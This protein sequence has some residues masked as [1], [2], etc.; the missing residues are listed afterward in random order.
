MW[1][2]QG[3]LS[4]FARLKDFHEPLSAYGGCAHPRREAQAL[5]S[6]AAHSEQREPS[7]S[8]QIFCSPEGTHHF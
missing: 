1:E 8:S 5:H 2:R 7:V 3:P 6:A 4:G